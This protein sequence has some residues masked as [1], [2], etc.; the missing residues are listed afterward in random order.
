LGTSMVLLP[1]SAWRAIWAKLRAKET[2]KTIGLILG[3]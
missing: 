3:S 2:P 1:C